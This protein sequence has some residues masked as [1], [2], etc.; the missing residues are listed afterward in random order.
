MIAARTPGADDRLVAAIQ[1]IFD[2]HPETPPPV[3]QP[4]YIS[5]L[6]SIVHNHPMDEIFTEAAAARRRDHE[7]TRSDR[8]HFASSIF[9]PKSP[10]QWVW[11]YGAMLHLLVDP[12]SDGPAY[13]P[14]GMW[15]AED[16]WIYDT[17]STWA[18]NHEQPDKRRRRCGVHRLEPSKLAFDIPSDVSCCIYDKPTG[19]LI[20]CVIRNFSASPAVLE[21]AEGIIYEAVST[22]KSIRVSFTLLYPP[23]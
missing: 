19:E 21:W 7:Y 16:Q 5:W 23:L 1:D 17:F 11:F 10:S 14:P 20:G 15:I 8:R 2:A 13:P 9:I 18:K 12:V 4:N 22:R 3:T 6:L